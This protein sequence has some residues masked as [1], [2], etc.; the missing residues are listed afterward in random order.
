M[1]PPGRSVFLAAFVA[2]AAIVGGYYQFSLKER[3][4][5]LGYGRVIVPVGNVQ[6]TAYLDAKAC[7]SK[8]ELF[9]FI[10]AH[11]YLSTRSF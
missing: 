2:L 10:H 3:L 7:E 11:T 1:I 6:C 8:F 5:I 4:K 9:S